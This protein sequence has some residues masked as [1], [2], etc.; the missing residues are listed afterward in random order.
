MS[1]KD[2]E[3]ENESIYNKVTNS[4]AKRIKQVHDQCV[5]L[6]DAVQTTLEAHNFPLVISGDHSSALGTIS[7]Y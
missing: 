7:W 5:R 6:S 4:F 1:L 3:T 2:L